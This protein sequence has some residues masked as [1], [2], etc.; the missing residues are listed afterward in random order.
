MRI[1]LTT[2]LLPLIH[3]TSI[4]RTAALCAAIVCAS[5]AGGSL[6]IPRDAAAAPVRERLTGS[7]AVVSAPDGAAPVRPGLVPERVKV[8][9]VVRESGRT[10]E[11]RDKRSGRRYRF[12][13]DGTQAR[14]EL[15]GGV[16]PVEGVA[17]PA[18][19][20]L[21]YTR[22]AGRID[23]SLVLKATC[24]KGRTLEARYRG[25]WQRP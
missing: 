14:G 2:A 11:I 9:L 15:G 25:S 20:T 23:L 16:F 18:V 22:I 19:S 3:R 12:P 5:T 4:V 8:D 10:V 7:V 13:F 21:S 6:I 24:P 1:L 17:C